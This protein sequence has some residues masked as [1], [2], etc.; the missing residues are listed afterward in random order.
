MSPQNANWIFS[1]T[2]KYS[3]MCGV[4][5]PRKFYAFHSYAFLL[6]SLPAQNFPLK[7]LSLHNR[8]KETICSPSSIFLKIY[9]PQ[10]QKK[11]QETLICFIKT[12][13][14]NMKITWDIRLFIF[15]MS[16]CIFKYDDCTAL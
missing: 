3:T 1:Q 10:Q 12:Q 16:F 4:D 8:Q 14:E 11:V 9:F 13:S 7:F 6:V 5:I 15:W 2:C